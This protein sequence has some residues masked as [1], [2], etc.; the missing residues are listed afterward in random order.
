[1][2]TPKPALGVANG[3]NGGDWPPHNFHFFLGHVT[4]VSDDMCDGG[5]K[6][7]FSHNSGTIGDK[8]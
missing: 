4:F 3:Q 5:I 8:I 6:L 2:A 1:V 7:V